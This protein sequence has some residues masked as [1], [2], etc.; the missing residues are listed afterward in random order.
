MPL[1]QVPT[2]LP[3]PKIA[4]EGLHEVLEG[5][6]A[7]RLATDLHHP[8]RAAAPAELLQG[9]DHRGLGRESWDVPVDSPPLVG[10]KEQVLKPDDPDHASGSIHDREP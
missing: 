8:E 2:P 7:R 6:D 1:E 5:D 10:M 4:E 9:R 3:G